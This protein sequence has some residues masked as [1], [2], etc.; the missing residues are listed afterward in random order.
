MPGK[1]GFYELLQPYVGFGL[2]T[3]SATAKNISDF[4]K[5]QGKVLSSFPGPSSA[6]TA[7][8]TGILDYLS[9]EELHSSYNESLIVYSGI[10]KFGG[11]GRA[12]P[13]PAPEPAIKS[14]KGQE[15]SWKDNKIFFRMTVPRRSNPVSFDTTG[16]SGAD[17]ADIQ[18][19]NSLL[20]EF[21]DD[22]TPA[23]SDVPGNDFKLELLIKTVKI[24]LPRADFIPARM[25][26]DGWLEPDPTV[27][28]VVFEFPTLALVLQQEDTAGNL[29]L[30]LKS[31]DAPGFDDPADTETA[32]FFRLTPPLFLHSSRTVGFG[33]ERIVADFSD[34][35]TPPE[36]LEQFGIGD[37]F[38]GFWIP[39]IRIFVAP[40]RTSGLAFSARGSDLL[41]DQDKGFSG[42]LALDILNRGGKLE[43]LPV[44]FLRQTNKP[45]EFTRGDIERDVDGTTRVLDEAIIIPGEAELH[46]SIRGSISPYT[47]E[48]TIDENVISPNI[49]AGANRPIWIIPAGTSGDLQIRVTDSGN[50]NRWHEFITIEQPEAATASSPPL[51]KFQLVFE[52]GTGDPEVQITCLNNLSYDSFA[53]IQL[54]PP[55]KNATLQTPIGQVFE[56]IEEGK[57]KFT[58]TP[59]TEPAKL[60]GVWPSITAPPAK[61]LDTNQQIQLVTSFNSATSE[62]ALKIF[63]KKS[64]PLKDSEQP[65]SIVS[66]LA[67]KRNSLMGTTP[68][69]EG[70]TKSQADALLDAFLQQTQG[71]IV[72]FGFASFEDR[73]SEDGGVDSTRNRKLSDNRAKVLQLL[74]QAKSGSRPVDIKPYSDEADKNDAT[75][76]SDPRFRVAVAVA[77][78]KINNKTRNATV[79]L[80]D[81]PNPPAI[82]PPENPPSPQEPARPPIFRRLGFR[83]RF[84]RSEL[85]LGEVSGEFD[86]VTADE[87]A[88]GFIKVQD[89]RNTDETNKQVVTDPAASKTGEQGIIDFRIMM[90]FD[91]ATR[92]LTQLLSLGFDKE[93]RDGW[94]SKT[95]TGRLADTIGSLLV[96]APLLNKG[97]DSA[98]NAEGDE[99]DVKMVIAATEVAIATTIGLTGMVKFVKFTL[100]GIELSASEFLP[101]EDEGS[102]EFTDISFLF[103]Y[104]VDFSVNINLGILSIRSKEDKNH[105]SIPTRIRYRA[106]GFRVNG[107]GAPRYESVFDTS[108]GFELGVAEP[109]ALMVGG[110]LGP[111]LRV[112][113]IRA[114]RQN[115]LILEMDLG[116]SANLGVITIDTVR[117]RMPIEPPGI[118][119]IIP[120]G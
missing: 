35:V 10:A 30:T 82:T 71:D 7:I 27:K 48:V 16:L 81:D 113:S 98:V 88:T 74:L 5:A 25:A 24:T 29:D 90:S 41:F 47:I 12:N 116:I 111:I 103:D 39:L 85:V 61:D 60:I 3:Q 102:A 45:L 94:V 99:A 104:A 40:S 31:W 2:L 49:S 57:Y 93:S 76:N 62:V 17:I 58:L 112:D 92:K 68:E 70:I 34:N 110:P 78:S 100:Y 108:K 28:N 66:Q 18:Q 22:G 32:S 120:T 115:P 6:L 8:A 15:L 20:N 64:Y 107:E 36:I 51:Q 11:E 84:E 23:I 53:L 95:A 38:N 55:Q 101:E 105:I 33:L 13:S 89:S 43:V 42:E 50:K 114:A 9:V 67:T 63:F 4:Q 118:P 119:T 21:K 86:F 109:G 87:E 37:D 91:T 19:L 96:F 56:P 106:I 75:T 65:A 97:I 83:V 44:F 46:L 1:L 117:V 54:S 80:V 72:V 14:K 52:D 73:G 77:H 69:I 79:R 59:G 26:A